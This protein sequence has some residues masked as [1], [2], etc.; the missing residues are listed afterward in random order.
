MK[1]LIDAALFF[2]PAG[3][4][5]M[6]P[7]IVNKIPGINRWNT[8]MDFG[9]SWHGARIFG[10]HKTWRGFICSVIAATLVGAALY[11]VGYNHMHGSL[12]ILFSAA[13]GAGALLGDAIKS[14]FKRRA[15]VKPGATWFPFDQLDY[16]IGGL[17]FALP[18]GVLPI[19]MVAA[20]IGIYF[21]GHLLITYIGYLLGFKDAPI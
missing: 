14:F 12:Y 20:I 10:D 16:I 15:N 2:L 9:R 1:L 7:L 18:F 3:I 5:N 11:A 21:C 13:L 19:K 6:T 17:L 4:A 8:P